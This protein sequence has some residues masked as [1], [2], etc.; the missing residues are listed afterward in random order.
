MSGDYQRYFEFI[1]FTVI[2][3]VINVNGYS[4]TQTDMNKQ[5]YQDFL[6]VDA[7]LNAAYQR[8]LSD[9]REDSLF[10]SNLKKTQRLWTQFRD[11]ELAMKYPDRG[12]LYYGTSHSMCI[13]NYL[14]E[15]TEKRI[16]TLVP[17]VKGV[18]EGD[19]CSGSIRT[20]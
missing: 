18:E 4:Q 17:W 15:L 10:I 11:S 8:I 14:I 6:E 16:E 1:C 3:I 9:Y 2:T 19:M 13:S 20:Y 12:T 5:A 7:K